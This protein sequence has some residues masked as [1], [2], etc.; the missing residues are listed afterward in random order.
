M[1]QN[2]SK[3]KSVEELGSSLERWLTKKKQY[4]EFTDNAGNPCVVSDDSLIAGLYRLMPESLEET[5]MLRADEFSDFES[6]FDKLSS[7]ATTRHSLNLSRSHVLNMSRPTVPHG[8]NF[9]KIEPK[10]ILEA[11][12]VAE[13][14]I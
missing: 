1:V 8:P 4:E 7:Y 11:N 14:T 12:S 6:F 9:R 10:N 13:R 2:P 5:F 3:C